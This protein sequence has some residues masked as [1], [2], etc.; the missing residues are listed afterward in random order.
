MSK[1]RIEYAEGFIRDVRLMGEAGLFTIEI[2]KLLNEGKWLRGGPGTLECHLVK[3][4]GP[5]SVN[6]RV[7]IVIEFTDNLLDEAEEA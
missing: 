6:K 3:G 1:N 4:I 5:E 7:K 2:E